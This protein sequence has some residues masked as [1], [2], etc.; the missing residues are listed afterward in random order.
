MRALFAFFALTAAFMAGCVDSEPTEDIPERIL[1]T[2]EIPAEITGFGLSTTLDVPGGGQG[3]WIHDGYLYRTNGADLHVIDVADPMNPVIVGALEGIGARDVDIVVW[4]RT[5]AVLAGSSQGVHVVDVTDPA[6]P[7]LVTTMVLPSAGVHNLAAVP[8]TPY[9]Y[10]SGASLQNKRIDILDLTDPTTPLVHT[11][12]IPATMNGIPV[13][14]DGCH[15]ITVRADLA[16]AYCAGGGGMYTGAGGETFIWDIT[17]PL[18]PVWLSMLDDPRIKYHH[19]AFVNDEGTILI[20]NDEFIAPNCHRAE[21]PLP[22]ALDPQVPFA[23]AWVYDVSDESNPVMRSF[24]Q[25]PA[26]TFDDEGGLD[27]TINCGSHFGDQIPGHQKFVM[28]WYQG[29]TMLVSY[30]DP[31]N[32]EIIDILDPSASTWDARVAQGHVFHSG[33]ALQVT[34]F[35]GP[36]D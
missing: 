32:P 10:S 1:T 17:D 3:L 2:A 25:N 4:D 20:V 9:V 26:G 28:G 21:T 22:G 27:P 18:Q 6:D 33:S 23:A 15:D 13:E 5:Y 16:R 36:Q 7:T 35:L 34:D 19:Q 14:S 24:V 12:P 29:G 31:D 8:G 11:F 30:D